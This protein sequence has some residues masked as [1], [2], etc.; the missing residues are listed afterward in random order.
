MSKTEVYC[1]APWNGLT[2]RED[3]HVR[4]CCVGSTSLGNLN[5]QT[6]ESIESGP[7]LAELR[8]AMLNSEPHSTNCQAC[9]SHE[10]HSGLASLRQ[11]Y[12]RYYP[13]TEQL[14]LQFVDIRWNNI[15]NLGCMYC[16]STFSSTWATR[17]P[18]AQ[19]NVPVKVYQDE[20]L[21]WILDRSADVK[22]IMLVG[23]EPMLMKQ[24]YT[25][26]AKLPL[27]SKIS[28]I[29]NLSYDLE[30][31]PCLDDL[32]KRPRNN[33]IWNISLENT[34]QQFEYVR[35]GAQWSQL[36]KNLKYV[37]DR[38][39]VTINAVYSVFSAFTLVDTVKVAHRLGVQKM[40]LVPINKNTSMD[41]Y[42]MPL[43]IKKIALE[44]LT[45]A[46]DWHQ[47][48]LHPEDRFLYPLVGFDDLKNMLQ[49]SPKN[50]VTWAKFYDGVENYDKWSQIKF[51]NLWPEVFELMKKYLK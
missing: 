37:S 43:E 51:Q 36:E 25:L 48:Q 49:V 22:E 9:I 10:A 16:D 18:V 7:V 2:I 14:K 27:D 12:L 40:N 3:G 19:K 30:N 34:E 23:G 31:L 21:D 26:L 38:W 41:M 6:I 42:N 4:T 1:T 39:P 29:T 11:H 44:Q 32:L 24:N 28:I 45:E 46:Q 33:I 20:L 8:Q 15:C 50:P 5:E 17:M 47:N 13:N 35:S